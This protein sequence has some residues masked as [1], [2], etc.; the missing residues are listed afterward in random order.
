MLR[1]WSAVASAAA[2]AYVLLQLLGR[3][4]GSSQDER[5][6]ALPGDDLVPR[7]QIVTDH[8]VTLDVASEDIWPWLTQMGW[9]LGGYYTP[10]WV[11]R[12]LFPENWSSLD[13]LDPALVRDLH[14][15]DIIPDGP[16]GTAWF[17]VEEADAPR[18]LVLHS[19]T[20]V[21]AGWRERFGVSIDWTW[22]F[23]VTDLPRSRDG[24]ICGFAAEWHR[25][26]SPGPTRPWSFRLTT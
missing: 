10:T 17:V 26:G 6:R 11:D 25:D 8:A 2:A 24:C 23:Q 21:P 1:M 3:R 20:H 15:G 5:Q 16:P 12:L 22:S 13:H 4:A 7:P 14:T 9:H 18:S 19:T